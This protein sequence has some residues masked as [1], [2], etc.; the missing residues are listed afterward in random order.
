MDALLKAD[1]DR[2]WADVMANAGMME[3]AALN[4]RRDMFYRLIDKHFGQ[5]Y[6]ELAE[7]K[8]TKHE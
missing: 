4:R 8:G 1:A 6:A 7:L 2:L 5:V 3:R